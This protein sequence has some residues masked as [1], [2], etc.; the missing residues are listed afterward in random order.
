MC[1]GKQ[2]RVPPYLDFSLHKCNRVDTGQECNFP[3][4]LSSNSRGCVSEEKWRKYSSP[5]HNWL[6]TVQDDIG[7]A[8]IANEP[9]NWLHCKVV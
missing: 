5:V 8:L 9:L 4:F 7:G 6:D 1:G 2:T 3:C